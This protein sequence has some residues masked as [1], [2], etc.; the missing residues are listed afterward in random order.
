M[1]IIVSV[2]IAIVVIAVAGYALYKLI[3]KPVDTSANATVI[4]CNTGKTLDDSD[5]KAIEEK[6][7]GD[8]S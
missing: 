2:L 7:D 5:L 3:K 8:N 6:K 4:K 1:I